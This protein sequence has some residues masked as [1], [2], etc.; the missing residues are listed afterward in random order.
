MVGLDVTR[1]VLFN[2]ALEKRL[3]DLNTKVSILTA[4]ILA[5]VGEEDLEEYKDHWQYPNDPVRAIHD[6][7][8]MAYVDTPE[9]FETEK[10]PVRIDTNDIPG[11]SVIDSSHPDCYVT[12]VQDLDQD[13]F[14]INL[15]NNLFRI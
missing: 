9:I 13:F 7:V 11:Q 6:I 1:T 14:V 2:G 5:S 4:K 12:V 3:N 10:V 8:A 15:L